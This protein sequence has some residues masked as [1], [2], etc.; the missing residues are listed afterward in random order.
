[1][2]KIVKIQEIKG[3]HK[4]SKDTGLDGFLKM[5]NFSSQW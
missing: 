3:P 4:E 1:M 2:N 5:G